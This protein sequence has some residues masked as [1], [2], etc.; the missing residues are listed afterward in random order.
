MILRGSV[1]EHNRAAAS[2]ASLT[3]CYSD[4]KAMVLLVM[5]SPKLGLRIFD[6]ARDKQIKCTI[7]LRCAVQTPPKSGDWIE[8][9]RT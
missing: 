2:D 9:I 4:G 5:M 8:V 7:K 3:W 6:R 1:A